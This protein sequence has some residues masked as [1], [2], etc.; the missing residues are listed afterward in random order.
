MS[1]VMEGDRVAEKMRGNVRVVG[2]V[3]V[4]LRVNRE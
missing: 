4:S 3:S 1:R 2:M